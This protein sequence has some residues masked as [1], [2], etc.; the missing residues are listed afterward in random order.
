MLDTLPGQ[1]LACQH[2]SLP[3]LSHQNALLVI[4]LCPGCRFAKGVDTF[5]LWQCIGGGLMTAAP[6]VTYSLKA[7][8]GC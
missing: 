5:F 8:L 6:A 2:T 7:R 4:A 1:T 3:L